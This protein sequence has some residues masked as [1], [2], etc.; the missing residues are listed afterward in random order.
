M[1]QFV[2]KRSTLLSS[3]H[4]MLQSHCLEWQY[5]LG[6]TLHTNP[7]RQTV[8]ATGTV[9]SIGKNVFGLARSDL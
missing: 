9:I 5:W 3:T 2:S 1:P 8:F 4:M 6:H 7:P